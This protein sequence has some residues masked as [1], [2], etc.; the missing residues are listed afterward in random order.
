MIEVVRST[1]VAASPLDVWAVLSD[2]EGISAWSDVVDHSCLMSD[3]TAG[4]GTVRRVQAGRVTLLERVIAWEPPSLLSYALEGLPP[5]VRSATNT[6]RVN[7]SSRGSTVSLA[8]AVDAG[9]RPPQR[10][11]AQ[12]AARRLAKTAEKL[13]DD[14][15][16]CVGQSRV[17]TGGTAT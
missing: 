10:L 13:L 2:F 15:A 16:T 9:P 6:W 11:I 1:D 17:P 3:Q 8:S 5:V 7:R 14:L 12:V 4:D